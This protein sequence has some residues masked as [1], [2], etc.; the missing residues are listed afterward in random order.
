MWEPD[1]WEGNQTKL[2]REIL[3]F[4]L[5][6]CLPVLDE[7]KEENGIPIFLKSTNKKAL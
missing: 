5:Q 7:N 4:L 3:A 6:H 1:N 2:V